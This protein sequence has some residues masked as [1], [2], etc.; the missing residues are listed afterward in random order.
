MTAS[1]HVDPKRLLL[2]LVN[3]KRHWNSL[4]FI[5]AKMYSG[6]Y[7]HASDTTIE[8]VESAKNQSGPAIVATTLRRSST[9]VIRWTA[10]RFFATCESPSGLPVLADRDLRF[11]RVLSPNKKRGAHRPRVLS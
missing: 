9:L 5:K 6:A 4:L 3:L 1:P 10:I 8:L 7:K 2:V 11:H